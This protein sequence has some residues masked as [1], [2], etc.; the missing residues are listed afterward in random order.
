MERVELRSGGCGLRIEGYACMSDNFLIPPRL[1][2]FLKVFLY[3]LL[4]EISFYLVYFLHWGPNRYTV[5]I[6]QVWNVNHGKQLLPP[7]TL[8]WHLS[9]TFLPYYQPFS[10]CSVTII[11][12]LRDHSPTTAATTNDED[13]VTCE[14]CIP[15][16]RS[17]RPWFACRTMHPQSHQRTHWQ[18]Q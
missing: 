9:A 17:S 16:V 2:H 8:C 6:L 11:A 1:Y 7:S 15:I 14:T 5:H 10:R 18:Q 12:T 13:P 4:W 3:M